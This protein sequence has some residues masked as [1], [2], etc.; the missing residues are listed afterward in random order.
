MALPHSV[1]PRQGHVPLRVMYYWINLCLKHLPSFMLIR[2]RY[3][4][5]CCGGVSGG[6][7][8][9]EGVGEEGVGEEGLGRREWGGVMIRGGNLLRGSRRCGGPL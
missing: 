5:L 9:G 7:G 4:L 8:V 1:F 3:G 2:R 6:E